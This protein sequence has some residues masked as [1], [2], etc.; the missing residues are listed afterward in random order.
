MWTPQQL[1]QECFIEQTMRIYVGMASCLSLHWFAI[2][3]TQDMRN[4]HWFT[5][6]LLLHP[7]SSSSQC[8]SEALVA[9]YE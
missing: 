5:Q 6:V 7:F 1:L 9:V 4:T 8:H 3:L 2:V